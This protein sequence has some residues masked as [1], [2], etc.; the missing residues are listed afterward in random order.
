MATKAYSPVMVDQLSQD[1]IIKETADFVMNLFD[2][3]INTELVLRDCVDINDLIKK[4]AYRNFDIDKDQLNIL[5]LSLFLFIKL[6]KLYSENLNY[7]QMMEKLVSSLLERIPVLYFEFLVFLNV[8]QKED[9]V[10]FAK[11]LQNVFQGMYFDKM[12]DL[13]IRCCNQ[14]ESFKDILQNTLKYTYINLNTE[15]ML[16]TMKIIL[17]SV[18]RSKSDSFRNVILFIMKIF[19]PKVGFN[20]ELI[21]PFKNLSSPYRSNLKSLINECIKPSAG[22]LQYSFWAV[23][24]IITQE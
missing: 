12:C 20:L 7:Y 16:E 21:Q 24:K 22:P 13:M 23:H 11:M 8:I 17:L 19:N 14:V 15:L 6:S 2:D 10:G 4:I 5:G 3:F 18:V 1:Q 9:H